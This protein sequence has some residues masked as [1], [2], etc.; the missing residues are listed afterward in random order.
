[1]AKTVWNEDRSLVVGE[2]GC[3]FCTPELYPP[4]L[5]EHTLCARCGRLI[6]ISTRDPMNEGGRVC[7]F[8]DLRFEET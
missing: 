6:K 4:M 5:R 3:Y 1:M 7:M 2:H 8:C